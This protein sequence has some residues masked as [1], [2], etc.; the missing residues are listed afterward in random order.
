MNFI[1][2]VLLA[3]QKKVKGFNEDYC[4]IKEIPAYVP[5]SDGRAVDKVHVF[6]RHGMRTD[7]Q[8]HSCFPNK[9][10]PAYTCSLRTEIGVRS[11]DSG[12]SSSLLTKKYK[13]GCQIGQLLDYAE[14]QMARLASHLSSAYPSLMGGPLFLRSTDTPRTLGSLD[15]LVSKLPRNSE[16]NQVHTEEFSTDPLDLEYPSC[17]RL[18]NLNAL[19]PQSIAFRQLTVDN[20]YY[21]ACSTMWVNEVGT[22]FNIVE[23]GDCL[24][25]PQCAEVPLPNNLTPSPE[26]Y[27]CV[28]NVYNSLR[29]LKYL[30]WDEGRDFCPLATTPL[31]GE[32]MQV[33]DRQTSVSLWATHDDVLACLLSSLNLWDG[34]WPQ[35]AAFVA[36]EELNDGSIRVIRDGRGILENLKWSDIL[37]GYVFNKTE[38]QEVC[39]QQQDVPGGSGV[40]PYSD[41]LLR[42]LGIS[43]ILNA[44]ASFR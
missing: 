34:V 25:A 42:G 22:P 32:L 39:Q 31:W 21:Q 40:S 1:A 37:P 23:A 36:F 17:P 18:N 33:I 30:T 28:K 5:P 8:Q 43:T 29:Q 20:D 27:A 12:S 7:F 10:Q 41:L 35:Y 26:L 16:N 9:A 2:F 13:T 4:G 24:I 3:F 19:F 38:F 15:L 44:L 6:F 11:D 14:V